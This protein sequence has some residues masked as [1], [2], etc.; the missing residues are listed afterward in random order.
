MLLSKDAYTMIMDL[1]PEIGLCYNEKSSTQARRPE[2]WGDAG[3]VRT[4]LRG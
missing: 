2:A 1:H 3:P 4:L